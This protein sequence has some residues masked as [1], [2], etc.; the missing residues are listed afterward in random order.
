MGDWL[1]SRA[2][3]ML[4]AVIA[5]LIARYIAQWVGLG[6]GD[7]FGG[8]MACFAFHSVVRREFL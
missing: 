4:V 2:I 7:F 5:G 8:W 1:T 3:A 6:D